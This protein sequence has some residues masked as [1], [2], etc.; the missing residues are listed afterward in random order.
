MT[1]HIK[2]SPEDTLSWCGETLAPSFHFANVEAAV[3]NGKHTKEPKACWLCTKE[4]INHLMDGA[5]MGV[6]HITAIDQTGSNTI[7]PSEA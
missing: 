7:L 6:T 4:I 5:N 1:H 2:I 3:L